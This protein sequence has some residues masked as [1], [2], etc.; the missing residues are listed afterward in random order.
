MEELGVE[1]Q[2]CLAHVRKNL[3]RRLRKIEGYAR[4]KER[5]RQIE[6]AA[7]PLVKELPLEDATKPPDG[8][9]QLVDLEWALAKEGER[10]KKLKAVVIDMAQRWRQVTCFLRREGVPGTNRRCGEAANACE[11]AIGRSKTR[12]DQCLYQV[13]NHAR[14]QVPRTGY[15]SQQGLLHGIALTQWLGSGARE[16]RLKE[17]LAA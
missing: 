10:A 9:E 7:K 2:L 11:P 16:H 5:L 15:K 4:E 12:A 14:I 13:Q 3:V 17:L 1:Q 6:D 8:G